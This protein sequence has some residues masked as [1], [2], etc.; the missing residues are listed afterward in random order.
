M[1]VSQALLASSRPHQTVRFGLDGHQYEID[2]STKNAT[3]LRKELAMF[4]EHGSRS[5]RTLASGRRGGRVQR[6]PLTGGQDHETPVQEQ[7]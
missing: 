7:G 1:Q 4:V 6:R 2:L 3:K 5:S